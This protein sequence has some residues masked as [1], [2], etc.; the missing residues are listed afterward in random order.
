MKNNSSK[1]YADFQRKMIRA[2]NGS[3]SGDVIIG[4]RAPMLR[5][6]AGQHYSMLATVDLLKLLRSEYFEART[7]ALMI[8]VLRFQKGDAETKKRIADMYLDNILHINN[9]SLVDISAYHVIGEYFCSED[10]IFE[11]LSCSGN[12]WENRIAIVATFAFI[13]RN[14]FRLTI[15]LCE[16]FM[17]HKHHLIHKACGWMLREVGKKN[18]ETLVNFLRKNREKMPRIMFSY[19]KERLKNV[20]L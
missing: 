9:W 2:E 17:G 6:M 20:Q 7:L 12:M 10:P 8:M 5:K 15:K 19:A 3:G 18:E 16:K 4:C 14:D 11:K 1:E 13:K